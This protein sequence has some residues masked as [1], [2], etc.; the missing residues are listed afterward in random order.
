MLPYLVTH[1]L[2]VHVVKSV[3]DAQN[4]TYSLPTALKHPKLFIKVLK[5]VKK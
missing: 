3:V 1:Y 5:G 2:F 4:S